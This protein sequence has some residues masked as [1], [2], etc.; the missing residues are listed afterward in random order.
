MPLALS[1]LLAVGAV[2][3]VR[4]AMNGCPFAL[5]W[6]LMDGLGSVGH[7]VASLAE[8]VGTVAGDVLTALVNSTSGD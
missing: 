1:I 3:I 4:D 6:L 2:V 8:F 5:V 7:V